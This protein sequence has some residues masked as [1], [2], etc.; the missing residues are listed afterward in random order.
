[1]VAWR[2]GDCSSAV[3]GFMV[4]IVGGVRQGRFGEGVPDRRGP[5][6]WPAADGWAVGV[7]GPTW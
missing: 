7:P 5:R 4:T 1:M 2:E 3:V 6:R